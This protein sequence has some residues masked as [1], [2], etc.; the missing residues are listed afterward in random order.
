LISDDCSRTGF[1]IRYRRSLL[2]RSFGRTAAS[3]KRC[4]ARFATVWCG[5]P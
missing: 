4:F 5:A 3:T 2:P 1:G